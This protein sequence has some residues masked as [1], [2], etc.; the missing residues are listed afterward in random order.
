MRIIAGEWKGRRLVAPKG[1]GVRPTLD[2][3]REAVFDVL[4]PRAVDAQVLDLFAGTGAMGLEALSRGAARVTWSDIDARSLAAIRENLG[5]LGPEPDRCEVLALPALAVIQRM[6]KAGRV[7]DIVFVDPPYEHGLYDETLLG[8]SVARIVAPE[9]VVVVEHARRI[10]VTAN[11]GDL[12]RF[13]ERRY[14]E[15]CISWFRRDLPRG[16][17]EEGA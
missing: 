12:L 14:G 13:K 4:G 1:R 17:E 9:G 16:P 2:M 3:V 7:F 15:T 11:Y 5:K 10:E 6:K 8:L